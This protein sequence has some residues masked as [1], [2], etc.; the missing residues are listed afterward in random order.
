MSYKHQM[1]KRLT[2]EEYLVKTPHFDILVHSVE[3]IWPLHSHEFYEI[4][5]I[6]SGEGL[7]LINGNASDISAGDMYL[8]TPAD[9]HEVRPFK[10]KSLEIVNVKYSEGVINEEL[11]PLLFSGGK[12]M[13]AHLEG[14]SFE[15]MRTE[16]FRLI[17]EHNRPMPGSDIIIRSGLERVLIDLMR[18]SSKKQNTMDF[19]DNSDAIVKA[20]VYLNHHFREAV[21]LE[22]AA[23]KAHLSANYFSACFHHSV[24]KSFQDYLLGLRLDHAKSLLKVSTMPVTDVCFA[25]GF[26]SVPY[27]MRAFKKHFGQSPSDYRKNSAELK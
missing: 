27:F 20:I 24:G 22:L 2:N 21:T 1:P 5:L 12:S 4:E 18:K 19:K 13:T 23:S 14:Q 11:Y 16:L 7:H 8:L 9:F 26:N 17:E 10:G 15:R 25:S 3:N 6:L